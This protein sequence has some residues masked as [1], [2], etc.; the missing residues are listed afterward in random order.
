MNGKK[1]T[2]SALSKKLQNLFS[3]LRS[4]KAQCVYL[5][6]VGAILICLLFCFAV[7]PRRYHLNVGDVSYE[8]ITASKDVVD[9][10]STKAQRDIAAA[11]VEP[12]YLYKDEVAP[13]VMRD[14]EAVLAELK[15]LQRYGNRLITDAGNGADGAIGAASYTFTEADIEYARSLLTKITLQDYQIKTALRTSNEQMDEMVRNITSAVSNTMNTTIREGQVNESIQYLQQII[16]YKTSVD[17]LQNVVTPVLRTVV[18]PNMVIDQEATENFRN[19]ARQAVEPVVYKQGQNIVLARERVTQNQLE[20]LRSLGLLD[21]E[22]FDINTYIGG[23]ML[24]LLALAVLA[25]T[26]RML[27]RKVLVSPKQIAILLAMEL[28]TL[29]IC[30]LTKRISIYFMPVLLAGMTATMLVG[31]GAGL[32]TSLSM[33]I[34][35]ASLVLGGDTGYGAETVNLVFNAI[36]SGFVNASLLRMKPYRVQVLLCGLVSMLIGTCINVAVALMTNASLVY[37]VN[38]VLWGAGGAICA[39]VL[40]LAL[41]P[42]AEALFNIAT[43]SKLMELCDPN[44]PLMRKMLLEAPGTYHHSIIVAN[45]A[46]AAAEAIDANP[47][48]ARAGAYYHDIGKL[49]RPQYFKENQLGEN[50]HEKINPYISAAIVTAHIHDG[51]QLA[52]EYH[53]PKE[54]QAI[55]REHHGDTPVAY[56]YHKAVEQAEG[57][58]VDMSDFRYDGRRPQSKESAVVMMADTV[59]AAVRSMQEPTPEKINQFIRKL[60]YGKIDDNQL[61][62]API[63]LREIMRACDAFATVLHGVFHERIEY[64]AI[65][66]NAAAVVAAQENKKQ[67]IA[68]QGEASQTAENHHEEGH[69]DEN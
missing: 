25:T 55:I 8:T 64:P 23:C 41:V 30:S 43:P 16:G 39:A 63:S 1:Q 59:E 14:L 68:Q 62:D 3:E 33:S 37:I 53:L 56:F 44:R 66:A 57:Q 61:S 11:L 26:L 10:I 36:I 29:A 21:D 69:K 31:Y 4:T 58:P 50:P 15:T 67:Q 6:A 52:Q 22:I 42:V 2:R 13:Q 65:S 60:V 27:S 18:K 35:A 45:L 24:V 12:T 19:E 32:A 47:M 46:E 48:L 34:L 20:M 7:T 40:C 38:D 54:V 9:E 17:L 51:L 49:K 5:F 28:L